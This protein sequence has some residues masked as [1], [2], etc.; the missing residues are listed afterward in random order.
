MAKSG[1]SN[2]AYVR[3]RWGQAEESD[4]SHFAFNK[5]SGASN[6]ATRT[7]RKTG[8]LIDVARVTSVGRDRSTGQAILRFRDEQGRLVAVRLRPQ[9]FRTLANGVLGLAE[10]LIAEG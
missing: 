2:S 3:P 10:A 1:A 4:S 7:P 8:L 5:Q 9:Q 6:V